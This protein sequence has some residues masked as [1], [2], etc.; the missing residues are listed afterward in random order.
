MFIDSI[1]IHNYRSYQGTSKIV[2]PNGKKN[3]F[4]IAG[5]NGFGKTTFLTSLVWCLYGKLMAD[6]DEKY[7][8]DIND[9]QGYKSFAKQCM[10]NNLVKKLDAF[11]I[12]PEE[13]KFIQKNGYVELLS[14]LADI[15]SYSIE[16][17][18]SDVFIPSIPCSSI[19]IHREYDYVLEQES[20]EVLIDGKINELAKEVG[21]DIFINDF[22]L[23]K[24]I[25]KFFFFDAEKIVSLAE[26]KSAEEKRKLSSAYGEVLG[27]KKYEDI[28]RNLENL[29][30]K[31]RKLSGVSVNVKELESVELD[32]QRLEL[33]LCDTENKRDS[34]D[35]QL[36]SLRTSKDE[37]QEKLIREGNAMSVEEISRQKALL[38]A[39][40]EK[41]ATLKGKLRE[42]L[43]IAPFAISGSL[44]TKLKHQADIEKEYKNS[45]SASEEINSALYKTKNQ[46]LNTIKAELGFDNYSY[47][48]DMI[49]KVFESNTVN[50]SASENISVLLDFSFSE[51]NEFQALYDNIRLSYNNLF[52][53]LVKDIK[54]NSLFL[55]KTQKKIAAAELD[56]T[57]VEIQRLRGAREQ[58]DKEIQIIEQEIRV[59]SENLGV[60]NKELSVKRKRLSELTK[61][62]KVDN[63]YKEKDVIAE[64][65]ILELTE[66][67]LRLR[68]SRRESLASKI[69][70]E[71]DVL[72]H[73]SDFIHNVEVEIQDGIMEIKLIGVDGTE[74]GKE[75]LSKG[76]QQLYA[77][78]ILKSLVV[79]SGIAFPVFIDSPLQ[80]FDR[81]HANNIITKF[82]PSVSKQVVIFPLLGKELSEEEYHGLMPNVNSTFVIQNDGSHSY[83]E[84]VKSENLFEFA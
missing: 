84:P 32:I 80:K 48:K 41:D 18:I 51:N 57:D 23:S 35:Q 19:T 59:L 58:I 66:L 68:N 3:V 70:S 21:Y 13:K 75:K 43:D 8:R 40:K 27:I 37:I 45:C 33:A 44:L 53:Q 67:L 55:A 60:F 4:L 78:A 81:V 38:Q 76:E 63:A 56:G 49:S 11:G 24:D 17:Q 30:V 54:N 73:K 65:L 39:L 7:R 29:R 9:A 79:E 16:I 6:V 64:R 28:K 22:I 71:L 82:Y 72:M 61:I 12:T 1:T 34:L 69:K 15:S 62:V 77:T 74:I 47:L 50:A 2:F 46:L 31:F 83:V 36:L 52:R 5:N 25:A 42:M 26:T 14:E 20:L 10:N